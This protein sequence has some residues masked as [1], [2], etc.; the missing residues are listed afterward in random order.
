MLFQQVERKRMRTDSTTVKV[1]EKESSTL[2]P[3]GRIK[4]KSSRL[5]LSSVRQ[6]RGSSSRESPFQSPCNPFRND[7]NETLS[8]DY[9]MDRRRS[10]RLQASNGIK[11]AKGETV[12]LV[13]EDLEVEE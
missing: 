4:M 13:D 6:K 3:C 10:P 2:N 5:F 1:F 7:D 8:N 11:R 9:Q 12:V